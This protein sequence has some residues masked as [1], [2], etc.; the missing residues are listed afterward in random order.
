MKKQFTESQII[1]AIKRQ[2]ARMKTKAEQDVIHADNCLLTKDFMTKHHI[3][4][5]KIPRDITRF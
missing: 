2:E 3:I 5:K 1:S 4:F